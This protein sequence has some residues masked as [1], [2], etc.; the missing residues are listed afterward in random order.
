L[1]NLKDIPSETW[2][3]VDTNIL[4]Y[5]ALDHQEYGEDCTKFIKRGLSQEI[6]LF[7]PAIVLHEFIHRLMIA[8]IME[9]NNGISRTKALNILKHQRVKEN[10]SLEPGNS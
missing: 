8:E 3:L 2:C 6:S 9:H 7:I 5:W 4:I 10:F 1:N